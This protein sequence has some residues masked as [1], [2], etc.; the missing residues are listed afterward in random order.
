MQYI[1]IPLFYQNCNGITTF[2]YAKA[3]TALGIFPLGLFVFYRVKAAASDKRSCFSGS[4]M[5]NSR[6]EAFSVS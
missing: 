2:G 5:G 6:M 3:K 4:P 1:I